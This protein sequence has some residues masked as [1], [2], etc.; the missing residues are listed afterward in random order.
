MLSKIFAKFKWLAGLALCEATVTA[1]GCT[2]QIRDILDQ[3]DAG[4]IDWTQFL[5]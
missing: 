3:V 4:D 1:N 2:D 5:Q